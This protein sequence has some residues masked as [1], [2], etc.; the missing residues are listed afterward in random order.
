VG[1]PFATPLGTA[2]LPIKALVLIKLIVGERLPTIKFLSPFLNAS[3]SV[4][5][6]LD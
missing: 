5:N 2:A 6:R 1:L 4:L 3:L